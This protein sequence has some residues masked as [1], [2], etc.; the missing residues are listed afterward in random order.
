MSWY[1][2]KMSKVN[3][4]NKS[5]STQDELEYLQQAE[6]DYSDKEVHTLNATGIENFHICNLKMQKC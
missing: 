4:T 5:K 6:T 1:L 2:S 3:H